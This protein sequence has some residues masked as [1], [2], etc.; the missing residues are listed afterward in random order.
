ML[1]MG[2]SHRRYI[3]IETAISIVINVVISGLFMVAVFGRERFIELWGFHGLAFDFVPQTFM[4][5]GMSVL[6]PTLLARRRI[7]GGVLPRRTR[8][9]SLFL[10][11]LTV[12]IVL[13]ALFFTLILGGI[14]VLLLAQTWK[15]PLRFWQAFPLK[16]FYG[17]LVASLATPLGLSLALSDPKKETL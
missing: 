17:A 1:T 14:G 4:I 10:R 9:P 16:L 5:S 3:A 15:G 6:V 12:R 2:I 13:L 7:S 11:R 8:P